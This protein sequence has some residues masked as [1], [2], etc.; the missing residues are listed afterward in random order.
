MDVR[1]KIRKRYAK[2]SKGKPIAL[3][4]EISGKKAAMNSYS[5]A[6]LTIREHIRTVS[7]TLKEQ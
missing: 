2:R 1:G 3:V 4:V 5:C 6:T 7:N